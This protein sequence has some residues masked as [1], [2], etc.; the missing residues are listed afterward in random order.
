MR[1]CARCTGSQTPARFQGRYY[2]ITIFI[3]FV[4]LRTGAPVRSSEPKI[5]Q[6]LPL[7]RTARARVHG[8]ATILRHRVRDVGYA[9]AQEG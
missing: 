9:F 7:L 8:F 2:W 5:L 1:R 6:N 4:L 3:R